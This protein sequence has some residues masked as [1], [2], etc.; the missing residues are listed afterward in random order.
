MK[1]FRVYLSELELNDFKKYANMFGSYRCISVWSSPE[2]LKQ[3]RKRLEPT[4]EM[5]VYSFG[6]LMWEIFNETIPF[7]GD[8]KACT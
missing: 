8:L 6:I 1:P 5:D 7:D 4:P 3:A 2:C